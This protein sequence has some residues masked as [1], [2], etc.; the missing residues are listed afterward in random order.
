[1]DIIVKDL[2][3]A[4]AKTD[5]VILPFFE[6]SP[7]DLYS[8]LDMRIGGLIRKVRSAKEF[9]GKLNQLTLLHVGHISSDRILLAG[10][11]KQADITI[12]RI[13]QAGGNALSHARSRG[14]GAIALSTSLLGSAALSE[15]KRDPSF[16]FLEGGLLGLYRFEKYRKQENGRDIKK[17]IVLGSME[18]FPLKRLAA[19]TSAVNFAK[20]LVMTP[21]ND[22]T[23]SALGIV[24][25]S[26]SGKKV[27]VTVLG[28]NAVEKAGMGAYLAVGKGSAEQPRF[29]IV[30]YKGGKGLPLVL[31]G[32][33][34]TFDSGGISLKPP[35][36]ME[37]M[38]YDMSGGAVVLGVIKAAAE[39]SLP[40]NVTGIIPAAENMP[41]GHA[42]RPGDVLT[43]ITGKTVEIIST[44]AEGR[45]I[46]A[47]AVGYAVK[48]CKPSA[49]IDI[50]TLTGACSIAFGSEAIAMMGTSAALMERLKE[51]S[52]ETYE[53]V[54]EM[55]LYDEYKDY[56]KSDVA[57]MKNAGG[58]SGSL[59]SA[60]YFLKEFAA[61]VPWVHLDIA[62]T[63]WNE[64]NKPYLTKGATAIGVRLLFSFLE[65]GAFTPEAQ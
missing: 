9:T 25:K 40:V 1:M 48:H 57:D 45:L 38:K 29:I 3:E 23:P 6:D 13:R 11:G 16:Y 44:D 2:S 52:L 22:M 15:A 19:V 32:K 46:L 12:D 42:C 33:A 30:E 34:I 60:G 27:K 50:A 8:D 28:K 7:P 47:D 53:R 51:A 18:N 37:K 61:E 56:L 41:G 43:T 55:P 24:A 36:G 64:K 31:V 4:A 63:A 39:L 14:C 62:G 58:R 35:E 5:L 54:W 10:L 49:I 20:D 65:Q 17:I 26:L 21:S 59:V